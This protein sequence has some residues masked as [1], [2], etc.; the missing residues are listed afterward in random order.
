M[1]GKM[2]RQKIP[3]IAFTL[4]GRVQ[5]SDRIFHIIRVYKTMVG[6]ELRRAVPCLRWKVSDT[7]P[8]ALWRV[9]SLQELKLQQDIDVNVTAT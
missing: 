2:A 6:I 8:L 9:L 3:H 1:V 5:A 7:Y 4:L